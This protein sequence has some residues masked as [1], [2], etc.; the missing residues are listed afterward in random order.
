MEV[1]DK[2]I[3]IFRGVLWISVI[4]LFII[5]LDIYLFQKKTKK[6]KT[7]NK[8]NKEFQIFRYDLLFFEK[9]WS[10]KTTINRA[11]WLV[12]YNKEEHNNIDIPKVI[13]G[14]EWICH[15]DILWSTYTLTLIHSCL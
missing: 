3:Q 10:F 14:V 15:T 5:N 6:H 4:L 8:K 1:V 12:D 11:S 7:Y 13:G 2:S 9:I